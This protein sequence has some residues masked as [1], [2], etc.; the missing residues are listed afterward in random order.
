M[1]A[2]KRPSEVGLVAL[3][4][5]AKSSERLADESGKRGQSETVRNMTMAI[6]EAKA[7]K[8]PLLVCEAIEEELLVV[9]KSM[10][11]ARVGGVAEVEGAA[12]GAPLQW[13]KATSD[14]PCCLFSIVFL[15]VELFFSAYIFVLCLY[16]V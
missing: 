6:Q 2:R 12:A 4:S 15:C 1:K 7:A 5:M 16:R 3:E 9:V 13:S 14:V 11:E 8:A 10:E